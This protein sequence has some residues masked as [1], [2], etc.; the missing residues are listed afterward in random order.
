MRKFNLVKSL[1]SAIT[2][3]LARHTSGGQDQTKLVFNVDAGR[4]GP[5]PYVNRP[6]SR[7]FSR[8]AITAMKTLRPEGRWDPN[9]K[10][11]RKDRRRAFAAG[12]K[13]AFA[14]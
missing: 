10:Q 9:Q 8:R 14:K 5:P 11:K 1:S 7:L 3:M 2:A 12:H 6:P 4:P 13:N